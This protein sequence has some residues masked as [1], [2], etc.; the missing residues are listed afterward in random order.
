MGKKISGESAVAVLDATPL[1]VIVLDADFN[2]KYAN[3]AA[4][5]F[6]GVNAGEITDRSIWETFPA[7]QASAFESQINRAFSEKKTIPFE[8][9]YPPTARWFDVQAT[10][11]TDGLAVY[12]LDAT[13]RHRVL[14]SA[15]GHRIGESIPK[16]AASSEPTGK[17][18]LL[19]DD[20]ESMRRVTRR[21][22]ARSGFR[23]IE[24]E[25]GADALRVAAAH[26]G[27]IDLLVTDVL[28]PG[29]R[30]PELVEELTVQSP[31]IRVLYMSGYTDDD[32]SRWGLQPGFAFIHK[33]FTSEGFTEAVNSVLAETR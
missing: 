6:T 24:A 14:D 9:H 20:D 15:Q 18:V 13:E 23:V 21:I 8:F 1:A 27:L 3:S 22:L 29:I 30:G 4:E 2:C 25:H 32:I 26:D 33:P 7:L 12:L 16:Q 19:V 10:P 5:Q 17:V 31:G 11:L 28:M